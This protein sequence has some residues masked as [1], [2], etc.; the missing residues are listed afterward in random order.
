MHKKR[1]D[2]V[3]LR[4]MQATLR[5]G[6]KLSDEQVLLLA[7]L[8]RE[9]NLGKMHVGVAKVDL[10][11]GEELMDFV[12]TMMS[13]VQTDRIILADGSLDAWLVGIFNDHVVVEDG[14]TGRLFRAD[15][16]RNEK[17]EIAFSEPIEVRQVFVP[18]ETPSSEE[19]GEEV[20]AA[21]SKSTTAR[22]DQIVDVAKRVDGRKWGFLPRSMSR[23]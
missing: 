17:G 4:H 15:F 21:V 16:S 13:A 3:A 1:K 9:N 8:H 14:N 20:A 22:F 7:G 5:K 18:V 11:E 23:R 6:E 12:W 2:A 10:R 19:G